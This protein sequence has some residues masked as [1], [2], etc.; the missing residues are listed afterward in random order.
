[1][2]RY[3][4]ICKFLFVLAFF[5]SLAGKTNAQ[6]PNN[7]DS[8]LCKEWKLVAF[9]EGGKKIPAQPEQKGDR[10]IFYFNHKVTSI[11]A[12]VN[13]LGIWSYDAKSQMLTITDNESKDKM[14]L[15]VLKITAEECELSF[16][17]D[18]LVIKIYMAPVIK[19]APS[20][21]K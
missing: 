4:P 13:E 12:G 3:K 16:K 5:V 18:D 14:Q 21:K 1:M 2:L 10:M 15:K 7:I 11:D 19:L 6:T 17:E 20:I 8:L 9:E